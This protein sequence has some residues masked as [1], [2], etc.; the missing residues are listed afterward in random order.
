[1]M[2]YSQPSYRENTAFIFQIREVNRCFSS[3][4]MG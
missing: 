2:A 3:P 1:M 4:A